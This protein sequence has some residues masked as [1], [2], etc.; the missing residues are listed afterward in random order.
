MSDRVT[1]DSLTTVPLWM[2]EQLPRTLQIHASMW[3]E[4][5]V[6]SALCSRAAYEKDPNSFQ[7]ATD[8]IRN[9]LSNYVRYNAKH[10]HTFKNRSTLQFL[11]KETFN[12]VDYEN[13]TELRVI[14]DNT[15]NYKSKISYKVRPPKIQVCSPPT[16][17]KATILI[18]KVLYDDYDADFFRKNNYLLNTCITYK[19]DY[20][21][22]NRNSDGRCHDYPPYKIV[23]I[24]TYLDKETL[25]EI[26][27]DEQDTE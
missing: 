11:F 1:T 14:L 10:L 24:D 22:V 17:E 9:H 20:I 5:K 13:N 16:V 25:E 26:Q 15:D 3:L 19:D 4:I 23:N 2:R 27:I 12:E 21:V 7:T 8:F 18:A 6:N